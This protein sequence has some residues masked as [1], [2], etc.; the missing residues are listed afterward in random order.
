MGSVEQEQLLQQIIVAGLIDQFARRVPSDVV[1]DNPEMR[2]GYTA[3]NH[4]E[5]C[6]I[7]PVSSLARTMPNYIVYQEIVV[8]KRPTM[9]GITSVAVDVL[10]RL[11]RSMCT[12][13]SPMD[14]PPPWY[15]AKEECLMC[16]AIPRYGS[17]NWDLPMAAVPL[18]SSHK[19][20]Y[21][22]F[23]KLLLEGS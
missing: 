9:R 8:G 19:D 1:M 14:D 18:P 5:T 4:D 11:G 2:Q 13:S 6:W 15:D 16:F 23:A 20:R 7:H 17:H 22:L 21:R 10:H 12:F 3:C